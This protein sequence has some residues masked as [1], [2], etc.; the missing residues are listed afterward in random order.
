M[1]TFVTVNEQGWIATAGHIVS[2]LGKLA[3]EEAAA[4]AY[5]SDLEEAQALVDPK[6]RNT[7]MKKLKKPDKEATRRYSVWWGG[8]SGQL[9]DALAVERVVL[10]LVRLDGFVPTEVDS[11]AVF[12]DPTKGFDPGVSLC[13]LGFPFHGFTPTWDEVGNTFVLPLGAI[14]CPL[15]PMD[16]IFTRTL[17]LKAPPGAEDVDFPL[18]WV[19]TSTPGLRGQ[20][21]GPTFDVKGTVWAIQCMTRHYPLG[22]DPAVPG[23]NGA[24]EHQFLNVGVGVHTTTLFAVF[25]KF[26]IQYQISDY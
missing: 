20:S 3:L 2:Q 23:G 10:G 11:Y 15:F 24:K 12:K 9:G 6:D 19:E 17:I 14:P 1:G 25:D 21:G 5:E 16:G 26:K 22:F 4:R 7:A 18:L 8:L 13:K